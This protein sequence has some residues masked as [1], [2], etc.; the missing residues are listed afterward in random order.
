M[1]VRPIISLAST[2]LS[3]GRPMARSPITSAAVPPWP[4]RMI[5]PKVASSPMPTRSSWARGRC[6]ISSTVKPSIAAP[7]TLP[8][9]RRQH[10]AGG[11]LHRLGGGEI[12]PDAAD[13][14]LVGDLRRQDLQ[15]DGKADPAC[16][17]GGLAGVGGDLGPDRRNAIGLEHRLGFRLGQDRAAGGEHL[18]DHG[19]GAI[20]GPRLAAGGRPPASRGEGPGSGGSGP[21]A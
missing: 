20:G 17:A 9:H 2:L 18:A 1:R 4:K 7:G 11:G 12:E 6:T 5:G 8:P 13:V 3:G 14:R 19:A 10:L 15:R 16:D 21:D